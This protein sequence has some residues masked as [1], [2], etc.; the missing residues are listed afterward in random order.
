MNERQESSRIISVR[1]A[2]IVVYTL[3]AVGLFVLTCIHFITS[4]KH[5]MLAQSE[6]YT[7]VAARQSARNVTNYCNFA[8]RGIRL[9]FDEPELAAFYPQS[10]SLTADE[11]GTI[12]K[13]TDLM[14]K[15]SYVFDYAD[16]GIIYST[17]NSA[18]IVS[19]GIK[20]LFGA[21]VYGR[22]DVTLSGRDECWMAFFSGDLSRACY[23]RRLNDNSIF[24]SS[25]YATK[26]GIVFN[27]IAG[28]SNLML[29]LTDRSDRVIYSSDNMNVTPGE[30][31]P[32]DILEDFD[33]RTNVIV[34][35]E[36]GA[37]CS[38]ELDSGWR[39]YSVARAQ[40]SGRFS[41]SRDETFITIVGISTLLIFISAGL[42]VCLFFM[43]PRRSR[44]KLVSETD[45]FFGVLTPFYCEEKISDLIETS[46]V[47]G[48]W[49]FTLVKIKDIAEIRERLGE[50]FVS[51][52]QK[53]L[54]NILKESFPDSAIGINTRDDFVVFTDFSDFDIFKAHENLRATHEEVKKQFESLLVGDN[55]DY[56]LDASMGVCIYPDSGRDYD[57][58]DSKAAKA[59][60]SALAMEGDSLVFYEDKPEDKRG[61]DRR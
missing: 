23:L 42:L 6:N 39:V 26:I 19:D 17:G 22:A 11:I 50:E 9:I 33:G 43:N 34:G 2:M 5:T 7:A 61:G 49:A 24:I 29:C 3:L 30:R 56:K 47:G 35:S 37:G 58:L 25:F 27:T 60:A 54:A 36:K 10:S 14:N 21:D 51:G 28:E 4:K 32:T 46:L 16:L 1:N 41:A 44:K 52:G 57:E 59:L 40:G 53:Q 15:A 48:T 13:I 55:G 31:L 20:S 12:N 18:G 38:M 45:D 8:E